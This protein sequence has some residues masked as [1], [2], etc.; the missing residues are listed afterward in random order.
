MSIVLIHIRIQNVTD[1][2]HC[3]KY[4]FSGS[5]ACGFKKTQKSVFFYTFWKP[6]IGTNKKQCCGAVPIFYIFSSNFCNF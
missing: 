3:Y 1:L 4:H 2:E 6:S 5:V